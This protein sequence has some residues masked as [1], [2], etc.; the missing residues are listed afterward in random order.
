[1]QGDGTFTAF[2]GSS[3]SGEWAGDLESG[4]GVLMYHDK[5][6]LSLTESQDIPSSSTSS[7]PNPSSRSFPNFGRQKS[8]YSNANG[9]SS[10]ERRSQEDEV[11]QGGTPKPQGAASSFFFY[12]GSFRN[13]LLRC[14]AWS[15]DP[16]ALL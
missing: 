9:V 8:N 14:A 15:C 3:Y 5:A 16:I 2:N 6:P 4:N 13:G 11:A 1:M 7:L 10:E 12:D